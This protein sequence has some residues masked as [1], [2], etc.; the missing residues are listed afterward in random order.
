MRG[1]V[2]LRKGGL[3][4]YENFGV[5]TTLATLDLTDGLL[6][7]KDGS[8]WMVKPEHRAHC[9]RWELDDF[10]TVRYA[11]YQKQ[12]KVG[13][14]VEESY[15]YGVYDHFRESLVQAF[16][17]GLSLPT[18]LPDP[19]NPKA[20]LPE[21]EPVFDP[22]AGP[23]DA[24]YAEKERA[25]EEAKWEEIEKMKLGPGVHVFKEDSRMVIIPMDKKP[26]R[27]RSDT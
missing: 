19:L 9:R 3:V 25:E 18:R 27:R 13:W 17:L 2:A 11:G 4:N 10:V 21:P 14:F 23:V 26:A 7:L 12:M 1:V 22:L 16:Y 20:P 8:W 24:W 6:N 15:P 5:R